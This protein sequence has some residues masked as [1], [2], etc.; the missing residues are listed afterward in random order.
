MVST[1]LTIALLN[2]I[3]GKNFLVETQDKP[4]EDASKDI[5]EDKPME[6]QEE[7]EEHKDMDEEYDD[8]AYYDNDLVGNE[9]DTGTV[10]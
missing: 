6:E 3:G 7:Q 10:P 1:V 4:M 8:T 2:Q 5:D 9:V